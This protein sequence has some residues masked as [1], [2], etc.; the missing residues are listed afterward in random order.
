MR[1]PLHEDL[2]QD[3]TSFDAEETHVF[4]EVLG[5]PS[6]E[7]YAPSRANGSRSGHVGRGAVELHRGTRFVVGEDA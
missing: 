2:T 3:P 1:D 4:G 5:L 7:L 6:F